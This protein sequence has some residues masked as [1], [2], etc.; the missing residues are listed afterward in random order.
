MRYEDYPGQ[1]DQRHCPHCKHEVLDWGLKCPGCDMVPRETP[2]GQKLLAKRR[3]LL[4]DDWL[5]LFVLAVAGYFLILVCI[6]RCG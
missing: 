1:I 5:I 6:G 4:W 3:K 2:E